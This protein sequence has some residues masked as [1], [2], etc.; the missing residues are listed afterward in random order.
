MKVEYQDVISG[1]LGVEPVEIDSSLQSAQCR[2]RLYW[3]NFEIS[4]PEDKGVKLVDILE[5]NTMVGSS[6]IRGRRLNKAT[7]IGRRLDDSGKRKDYD[8]TV[9]IIQCLEVRATNRDK[10]NCLTTVAKDNVLTSMGIGRHPNAFKGGL[11]FRYYT[12]K[13]YCRLQTVPENYFEG[14]VSDN[15]LRKMIGNGW[16]VDVIKHILKVIKEDNIKNKGKIYV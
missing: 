3:G 14:V 16:T 8:K 4:Q 15:Q 11:P 2:K 7:I 9:P 13:E 5:D 12:P 1:Y 6:V 10:C